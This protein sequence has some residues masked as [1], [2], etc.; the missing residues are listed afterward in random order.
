M[1][2]ALEEKEAIKQK[3]NEF[4]NELQ[5]LSE[6]HGLYVIGGS[7]ETFQDEVVAENLDYSGE[8]FVDIVE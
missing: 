2:K 1:I 7:I 5:Q 6:K 3:V 8:Y 4:L